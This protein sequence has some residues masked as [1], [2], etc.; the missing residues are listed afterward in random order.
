M[1]MSSPKLPEARL[2]GISS[3]PGKLHID[4]K[5]AAQMTLVCFAVDATIPQIIR[6][7]WFM[8]VFPWAIAAAAIAEIQRHGVFLCIAQYIP[9][10]EMDLRAK[11]RGKS[12]LCPMNLLK[13]F[14]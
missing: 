14:V 2:V 11:A 4:A 7:I 10:M 1:G 9:H 8:S 6:G 12:L 13:L 3:R 5:P